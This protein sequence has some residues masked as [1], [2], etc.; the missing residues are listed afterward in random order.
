MRISDVI[1]TKSSKDV[2]TIAPDDP[3]L[4]TVVDSAEEGWAV[5]QKAYNLP[6]VALR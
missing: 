3:H 5:V 2:I 4:F 6:D 1:G